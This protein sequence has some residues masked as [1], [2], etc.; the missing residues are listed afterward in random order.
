MLPIGNI[1]LEAQ[2]LLKAG[3]E[4]IGCFK[5]AVDEEGAARFAL[6]CPCPGQ[7]FVVVGVTAEAVEDFHLRPAFVFFAEDLHPLD[8]IDQPPTEGFRRLPTDDQDGAAG[9][10]DVVFQVM[11]YTPL[12]LMMMQGSRRKL[13]CLLS[14]TE[15]M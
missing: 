12:A 7:Q 11:Q 2:L 14:S 1:D 13:S 5:F 8:P 6:E 4:G 9:V 10:F 15:R 3:A